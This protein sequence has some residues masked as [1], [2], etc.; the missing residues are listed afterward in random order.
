MIRLNGFGA[1]DELGADIAL[2]M[3]IEKHLDILAQT[4]PV[5]LQ[6]NHMI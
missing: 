6:A 3:F 2:Q 5:T 4:A 1:F